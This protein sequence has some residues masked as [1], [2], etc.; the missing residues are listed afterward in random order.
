[1]RKQGGILIE[2]LSEVVRLGADG[3]EVEYEDG[4]EEVMAFKGNTGVGIASISSGSPQAV[5]LSAQLREITRRKR[6]LRLGG[7]QYELQ[8]R[9]YES[10]GEAAFAVKLRRLDS[11]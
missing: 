9:R 2:L 3:L 1:M 4:H 5:A 6:R 7:S 8:G 11:S 10:F